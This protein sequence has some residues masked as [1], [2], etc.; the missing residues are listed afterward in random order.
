MRGWRR[1]HAWGCEEGA[2]G[3]PGAGVPTILA[4][5]P[6]VTKRM[7]MTILALHFGVTKR[8]LQSHMLMTPQ[9]YMWGAFPPLTPVDQ[10]SYDKSRWICYFYQLYLD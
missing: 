2:S 10:Q 1:E 6:G 4:G 9:R 3:P 8:F 7:L 5:E